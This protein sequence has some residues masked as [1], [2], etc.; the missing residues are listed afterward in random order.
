MEIRSSLTGNRMG[1][2]PF[3][4][5]CYPIADS[6]ECAE[7]LLNQAVRLSKERGLDF[8]EVRGAPAL[9]GEVSDPAFSRL[10]DL[11]E[12]LGF[13]C[14]NHFSKFV[15]PLA[16]DTDAVRRALQRKSVRQMI[17]KSLRLGVTVRRGE[18]IRDLRE[19]YRLYCLMRRRHG[20]PPQPPRL[21]E[22]VFAALSGSPLALLYLA[23]FEQK[24]IGALI[25]LHY[26]GTAHLKYE[27]V[28]HAYRDRLPVYSLFWRSIEE[29]AEAGLDYCDL[30]RTASDNTGL[31]SFKSHWGT[32]R[33]ELPYY[34][35]PPAEGISVVKSASL[36][37]RLFTGFF[38][39]L[40]TSVTAYLGA[41]LFRHFG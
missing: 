19:F 34:S 16:E 7:D 10:T 27:G 17:S 6:P 24:N 11:P 35:C 32:E 40:P 39:R 4:D 18:G 14:Q 2:L 9:S 21:F 28:D 36:K 12:R 1:S 37:Y 13:S 25:V 23:E 5:E 15:L 22:R 30:G 26:H 38:K 41:R 3:S 8:L 31:A 29:A 33:V 20:I